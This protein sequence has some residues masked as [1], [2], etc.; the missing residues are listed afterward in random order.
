MPSVSDVFRDGGW[1]AAVLA[2]VAGYVDAFAL[3]NHEVFVSFMS[4]NTTSTG[5]KAG[6]ASFMAAGQSLLPIPLFFI[7]VFVGTLVLHS[8][9]PSPDPLLLAIIAGLIAVVLIGARLEVLAD[10]LEVSLLSLAMGAMN[11]TVTKAGSQ[12][13][14]L[15]YVTGTLNTAAQHLALAVRRLPVPNS[16]GGWD[17]HQRRMLLLL[18]VWAGFLIGALFGGFATH[19]ASHWALLVP[20]A[21]LA[22]V[23]A[24]RP[25]PI[26]GT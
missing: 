6:E 7:G 1:T 15:G 25:E 10:W 21:I 26:Q 9:L 22:T 11:T 14:S 24:L 4:G 17:T 5:A 3:L 2:L 19:Q 20:L 23:V 12:S 13:V 16:R 8:R 18:G